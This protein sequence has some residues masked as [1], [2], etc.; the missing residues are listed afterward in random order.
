MSRS[1]LSIDALDVLP[2]LGTYD[3]WARHDD[4]AALVYAHICGVVEQLSDYSCTPTSP[5]A[6]GM[7]DSFNRRT[8]R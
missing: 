4:S 3:W 5:L 8:I 2:H 1:G 6:L 7:P